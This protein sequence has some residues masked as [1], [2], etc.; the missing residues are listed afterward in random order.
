MLSILLAMLVIIGLAAVVVLDVACPHRGEE[1]PHAP[2]VGDAMRK[3]VEML[4]TLD[5]HHEQERESTNV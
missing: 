2:W 3:G 4:P 1:V 5:N